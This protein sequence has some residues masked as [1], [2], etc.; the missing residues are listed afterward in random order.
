L[1]VGGGA[2]FDV[3]KATQFKDIT[4]GSSNTFMVVEADDDHAVI[5]TKPEDLS[6]DAKDPTKGLGRF[7]NGGF[8]AV[9]CDGSVQSIPWPTDATEIHRLGCLFMRADGEAVQRP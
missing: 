2:V 6:F 1:P 8:N 3:D 4:D 5:W 9:F 7:F